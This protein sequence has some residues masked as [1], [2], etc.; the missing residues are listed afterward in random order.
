VTVGKVLQ[1]YLDQIDDA[2]KAD[3]LRASERAAARIAK[4]GDGSRTYRILESPKGST[5]YRTNPTK[6]PRREFRKRFRETWKAENRKRVIEGG[7]N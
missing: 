2:D 7:S 5:P 6:L 3:A 4:Y 1:D